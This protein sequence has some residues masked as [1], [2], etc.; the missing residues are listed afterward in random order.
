MKKKLTEAKREKDNSTI[1]IGNNLFCFI[2]QLKTIKYIRNFNISLSV[3]DRARHMI[4]KKIE[5]LK[6]NKNQLDLTDI[7]GTLHPA[8]AQ[9]IFSLNIHGSFS[10]IKHV[11]DHKT[12]QNKPQ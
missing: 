12:N 4:N 5:D 6:N 10:R 8:I 9:Y 2:F 7:Y 3:M 11:S 1:L